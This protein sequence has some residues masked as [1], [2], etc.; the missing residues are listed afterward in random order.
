MPLFRNTVHV[1]ARWANSKALK[2]SEILVSNRLWILNIAFSLMHPK[3]YVFITKT[4]YAYTSLCFFLSLFFPPEFSC[5][6]EFYI[7][8]IQCAHV[9]F[10]I[11]IVRRRKKNLLLVDHKP[12]KI[13]WVCTVNMMWL[14]KKKYMWRWWLT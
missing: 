4:S 14:K 8:I 6:D 3:L 12:N 1:T 5:F 2:P 9:L 13:M 10:K 7:K 11:E